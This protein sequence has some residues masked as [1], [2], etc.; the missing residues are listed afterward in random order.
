M[1]K[2]ALREAQWL[3]W[4]L[5]LDLGPDISDREARGLFPKV[6][7]SVVPNQPRPV[8]LYGASKI[9]TSEKRQWKQTWVC[10]A[11]EEMGSRDILLVRSTK[12]SRLPGYGQEAQGREGL[13]GEC[14]VSWKWHFAEIKEL[15]RRVCR[16]KAI[17]L[18]LLSTINNFK[19]AFSSPELAAN[20]REGHPSMSY[21]SYTVFQVRGHSMW[22]TNP[23]L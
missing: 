3:L 18:V 15:I 14:L 8:S 4:D 9:I 19:R 12:T 16:I 2:T 20:F 22:I 7:L 17:L 10:C 21:R 5:N 13:T 6:L 23:D 1:E 11:G